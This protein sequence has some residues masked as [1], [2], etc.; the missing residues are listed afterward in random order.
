MVKKRSSSPAVFVER[1]RRKNNSKLPQNV[2]TTDSTPAG[3][4]SSDHSTR[5][6]SPVSTAEEPKQVFKKPGTSRVK[7]TQK[8]AP[9][10]AP[11]PASFAH[12]QGE[13]I[14]QRTHDMD[15]WVLNEI[16]A[17][18]H[19]MEV[20]KK[21]AQRPRF[22]PKAPAKR[23]AERHPEE[24]ASL[25]PPTPEGDSAMTDVSDEAADDDD[26][27]WIIEEYVRIP[28][29]SMG[30]DVSPAEVGVLVLEGDEDT[31]L[32][33]G[34]EHDEDDDYAE[35][36][37]DENGRSLLLNFPSPLCFGRANMKISAENHYTADYPEDEVDS[38]DEYGRHAY[39]YRNA[40]ASD[41]EMFD[42]N[43]YHSDSDEIVLEGNQDDD[44]T[45]ARIKAYMRRNQDR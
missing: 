32:F 16:G 8:D 22:K 40:N 35:D 43:N 38:D 9:T 24:A 19:E 25:Q 21:E 29:K 28:A 11:P 41:D 12:P 20:E 3:E 27:D 14:G 44:A 33:F 17:N 37:E 30:V 13:D 4:V 1:S 5:E 7:P 23:W 31:T 36:D 39:Y 26:D 18:L 15:Q 2:T 34:L 10:R 45:M 6:Q 42:N